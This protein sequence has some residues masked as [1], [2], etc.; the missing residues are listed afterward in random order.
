MML[1]DVDD[2]LRRS[3]HFFLDRIGSSIGHVNRK[4][5]EKREGLLPCFVPISF[6]SPRMHA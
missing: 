1:V 6:V 3:I 2:R 5:H 4:V